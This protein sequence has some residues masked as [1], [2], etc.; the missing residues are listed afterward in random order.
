MICQP[1]VRYRKVPGL[2][3]S[4]VPDGYVAYDHARG[5]VHFLNFTA[6]SV[7]DLCDGAVPATIISDRLQ[8]AFGLDAS[9][10]ADVNAC[11]DHLLAEGIIEACDRS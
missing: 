6:A 8:A 4:E 10:I 3:I 5:Q 11:L 7:L 2:D 9:P 1:D